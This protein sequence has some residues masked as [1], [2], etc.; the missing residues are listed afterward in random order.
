MNEKRFLEITANLVNNQ[1]EIKGIG[2]LQE[3]LLHRVIKFYF[4][5]DSTFH[6]IKIGSFYADIFANNAII[7]IQT[8]AFNA[9]RKKLDFFLP[10]YKVTLVYPI[11]HIKW[12]SWIDM[13][14]GEASAK[15]KSPKKGSFYNAFFELYKIK[16]YLDNKNLNIHL[17]LIDV[18]DYRYLNGWSLNKKKGSSRYERIPLKLID[19]VC[20]TTPVDY[21]VFLPDSLPLNFTSKDYQKATPLNLHHSQIALNILSSLGVVVRVGKAKN[22][23]V[24]QKNKQ[25]L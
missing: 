10:N 2:T 1:K 5:E 3:K 18:E 12:L 17:M 15:R 19:E 6:E 13:E 22:S 25:G 4:V 20:L 16:S 8:R 23:I 24:Y 7:E 9:L 21:N 11:P 14:T